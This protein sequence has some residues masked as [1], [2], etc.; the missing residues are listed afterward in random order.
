MKFSVKE[1]IVRKP[2]PSTLTPFADAKQL[3]VCAVPSPHYE[4][5]MPSSGT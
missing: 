2:A 3:N 4:R 1:F 5:P